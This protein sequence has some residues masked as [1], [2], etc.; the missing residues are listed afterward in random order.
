[1]ASNRVKESCSIHYF[2][3]WFIPQNVKQCSLAEEL[4]KKKK[5]TDNIEGSINEQMMRG[6]KTLLIF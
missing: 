4:S 1:M 5:K 2:K 6:S 3:Y